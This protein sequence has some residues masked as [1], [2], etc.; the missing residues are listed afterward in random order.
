MDSFVEKFGERDAKGH[1]ALPANFL[2]YSNAF[3]SLC[4]M[5][6]IALGSTI[7]ERFGRRLPIFLMS[8][9][10]MCM[11]PILVT[12]Q[13]RWQFLAGRMLN[14][15]Y[16]GMEIST[17]PVFQSEIVPR[18]V[19]G[20]AVASF[21]LSFGIGQ[22]IMSLVCNKTAGLASNWAWKI[23]YLCFLIGTCCPHRSCQKA[24]LLAVPSIVASSIWFQPESPR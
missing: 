1:Y 11:V 7:S 15:V 22:L 19:R 3:P 5:I 2:S 12:S 24:E 13:S 10:S 14:S 18:E 4:S 20:L 16:T 17:I 6:G 21:Q 8:L 9:W 23:P